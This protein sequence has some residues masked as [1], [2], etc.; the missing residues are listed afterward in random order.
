MS[1]G[2]S[3]CSQENGFENVLTPWIANIEFDLLNGLYGKY[4][5]SGRHKVG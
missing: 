5:I 1:A 4:F 2:S 3:G